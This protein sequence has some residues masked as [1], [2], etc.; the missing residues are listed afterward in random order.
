MITLFCTDLSLDIKPQNI[1]LDSNND[2]KIGDF[3]L[4]K[5]LGSQ[6]DFAYTGVGTPL[7]ISPEMVE[8]KPYNEKS[9]VW[10]FGCLMYEMAT[11]HPPFMAKNQVTLAK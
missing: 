10:A 1:F 5:L 6:S 11:K 8:E 4:S 7:Y 9:D 3:G 2:I